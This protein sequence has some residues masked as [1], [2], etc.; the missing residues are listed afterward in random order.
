MK[1]IT[2]SIDE[3]YGKRVY[4]LALLEDC[5]ENALIKIADYACKENMQEW[6]GSFTLFGIVGVKDRFDIQK[7][8]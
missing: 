6:I 2:S 1:K 8:P 7:N 4:H 5:A 3:L